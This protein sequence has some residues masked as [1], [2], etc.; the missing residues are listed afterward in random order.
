MT[1]D[2]L[3]NPT[4]LSPNLLNGTQAIVNS[5]T[6][7]TASAGSKGGS[8]TFG[9]WRRLLLWRTSDGATDASEDQDWF[10]V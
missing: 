2:V 5:S 9:L 3:T 8:K 7:L 6:V 4:L 10:R 1:I